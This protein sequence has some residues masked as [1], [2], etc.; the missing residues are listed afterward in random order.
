MIK[1]KFKKTRTKTRKDGKA[2]KTKVRTRK[3]TKNYYKSKGKSARYS[4]K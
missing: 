1:V 3:S 2:K 4:I